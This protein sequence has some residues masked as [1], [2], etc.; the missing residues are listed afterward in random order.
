MMNG[1]ISVKSGRKNKNYTSAE[2]ELL[3]RL[4]NDHSDI[5]ATRGKRNRTPST[6]WTAWE[7][8]ARVYNSSNPVTSGLRTKEQLRKCYHNHLRVLDSQ[9]T[10]KR[11]RRCLRDGSTEAGVPNEGSLS[12]EIDV[13]STEPSFC[14]AGARKSPT[15]TR[16]QP[17]AF[18]LDIDA[19]L[20]EATDVGDDAAIMERREH[21]RRMQIMEE[22]HRISMDVHKVELDAMKLTLEK[23]KWDMK[24]SR[25]KFERE[26]LQTPA[27]HKN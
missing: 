22:D 18:E 17:Q 3:T 23:M 1:N 9:N 11:Q 19:L 21:T 7:E 27:S 25:A 4:G 26:F 16:Q 8:I 14:E 5:S 6:K 12:D 20:A 24:L 15:K 10:N 13:V 2:L